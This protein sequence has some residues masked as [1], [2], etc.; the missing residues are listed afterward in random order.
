M[1]RKGIVL[2]LVGMLSWGVSTIPV[3]AQGL[4]RA[5]VALEIKGEE[6]AVWARLHDRIT[7]RDKLRIYVIPQTDLQVYVVYTNFEK[8]ALMLNKRISGETVMSLPEKGLYFQADGSKKQEGF[9]VICAQG[10]LSDLD[11]LFVDD[12][13]TYEK[14]KQVE[15]QLSAQGKVQIGQSLE[16]PVPMAGAVRGIPKTGDNDDQIRKD[17][18]TYSGKSV[19]VR[20]YVLDVQK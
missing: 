2:V 4:V 13:T 5:K 15:E 18:L 20:Q 19:L 7:S 16:K 8:A 1:S 14:W 11:D 10:P 12:K 9:T 17:L 3:L 6:G